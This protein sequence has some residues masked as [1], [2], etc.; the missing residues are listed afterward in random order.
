VRTALFGRDPGVSRRVA[1]FAVGLGVLVGAAHAAVREVVTVVGSGGTLYVLWAVL[2]GLAAVNAYR[3][4][5]VLLSLL[6]TTLPLFGRYLVAGGFFGTSDL[7]TRLSGAPL[8]TLLWGVPLAVVGY[9]VGTAASSV[10]RGGQA[11]PV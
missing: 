2:A 5:G 11:G 7:L 9:L 4:D 1:L 10:G 8:G 6:L 3:N